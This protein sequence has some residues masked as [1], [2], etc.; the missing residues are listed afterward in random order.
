MGKRKM[1]SCV[2]NCGQQ[3]LT[4]DL[5]CYGCRTLIREGQAAREARQRDVDVALYQ[6]PTFSSQYPSYTWAVDEQNIINQE[7]EDVRAF[8]RIV[9]EAM[10][11][12]TGLKDSYSADSSI[13]TLFNIRERIY[14]RYEQTRRL[15]LPVNGAQAVEWLDVAV[16]RLVRAAYRHGKRRGADLL[17]G[18]HA[19]EITVQAMD[20]AVLNRE[21]RR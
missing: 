11:R 15:L 6:V 17:M 14:E 10:G 13:P 16:A 21:Q 8:L 2:G 18:L 3:V 1:V 19:G 9:V 12:R 4:D 7:S 5:L 20:D